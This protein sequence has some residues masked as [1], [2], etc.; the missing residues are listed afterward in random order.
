V[1]GRFGLTAGE[2]IGAGDPSEFCNRELW[3]RAAGLSGANTAIESLPLGYDT[4][5]ED[6]GGPAAAA[7][8]GAG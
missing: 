2:N 6:G 3:A 5:L 8:G 4:L 7:A 1:S